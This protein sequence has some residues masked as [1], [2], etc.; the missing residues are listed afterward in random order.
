MSQ[1]LSG[2]QNE[3]ILYSDCHHCPTN[4]I[5]HWVPP[6]LWKLPLSCFKHYS[7]AL[8][9]HLCVNELLTVYAR[10]GGGKWKCVVLFYYVA[11]QG[12]FACVCVC[13]C[14]Q[15]YIAAVWL[16]LCMRW[17]QQNVTTSWWGT[18]LLLTKEASGCE[19]VP[20]RQT[21]GYGIKSTAPV[22]G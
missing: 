12:A 9:V 6:F 7:D 11:G 1:S 22:P 20:T 15:S 3:S 14:E 13:A 5:T 2:K 21:C 16:H 10:K 8:F 4:S 18:A 17:G 19:S